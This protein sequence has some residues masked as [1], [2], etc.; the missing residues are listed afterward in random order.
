MKGRE[1]G[2]EVCLVLFKKKIPLKI[3][4]VYSTLSNLLMN[5][6]FRYSKRKFLPIKND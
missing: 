1:S 4:A 5:I 3:K 2:K 6:S